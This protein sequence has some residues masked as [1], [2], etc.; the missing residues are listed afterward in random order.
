MSHTTEV[1]S[2]SVLCAGHRHADVCQAL[3]LP[4]GMHQQTAVMKT[5]ALLGSVFQGRQTE[6]Q[7]ATAAADSVSGRGWNVDQTEHKPLPCRHCPSTAE[8]KHVRG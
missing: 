6:E 2:S 1:A 8:Q 3:P 5:L 7:T 4:L